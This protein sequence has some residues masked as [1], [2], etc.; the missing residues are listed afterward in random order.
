MKLVQD[1]FEDLENKLVEYL[2][3]EG[4]ELRGDEDYFDP[5]DTANRAM[6]F[7]RVRVRPFEVSFNREEMVSRLNGL[8]SIRN[9]ASAVDSFFH[10]NF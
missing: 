3:Q 9:K 8:R 2:R 1:A 7:V 10:N 4:M 6:R 5:E